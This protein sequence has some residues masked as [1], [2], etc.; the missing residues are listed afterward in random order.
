MHTT[1]SKMALQIKEGLHP[2]GAIKQNQVKISKNENK[3]KTKL[4]LV[5]LTPIAAQL[6]K[7]MYQNYCKFKRKI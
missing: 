1:A 4:K 7:E 3:K 6:L 2:N 5:L